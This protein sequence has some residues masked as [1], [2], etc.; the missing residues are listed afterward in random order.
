MKVLVTHTI[1]TVGLQML[2]EEGLEVVVLSGRTSKRD[3]IRALRKDAYDGMVTLLTDPIDTEVL[4]AVGSDMRIIANYAVGYNNIAVSE[5]KE[6]GIIITNT[7]GVL[8]E[9]VAEHTMTLICAAAKRIVEADSFVRDNKF[10][11]WEPEL[12]L[13]IDLHGKT[14][15]ILGAG[16]IGT[17]VAELARGFGMNIIYHDIQESKPLSDSTGAVYH[18]APEEVLRQ[19]DVISVHLPL[20]DT[21]HHFLDATRLS[22]LKATA[23]VVNTSR[24][25]I[26]D[27]DALL[28]YLLRKR[29]LPPLLMFL[30][31][32]R[33]CPVH[34][35]VC[36]M[37]CSPR[38]PLL[39]VFQRGI[40]CQKW[41]RITLLPCCMAVHRH[42]ARQ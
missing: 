17:R 42:A 9:T 24:G 11:G 8:T 39:R 16:R 2:R 5:A 40:V 15:G 10:T 20:T 3:I 18:A 32:N 26:I 6:R 21:T 41:L 37:L 19:A 27:E 29:F 30:S 13:G 25:P 36:R 33:R 34:F 31:M 1:P 28:H 38:T 7:P 23:I 14:L 35:V 22:F 12:F 4:D